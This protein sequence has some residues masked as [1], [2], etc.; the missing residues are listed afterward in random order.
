MMCS[1]CSMNVFPDSRG[2]TLPPGGAGGPDPGFGL[3]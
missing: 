2:N 1:T 3:G